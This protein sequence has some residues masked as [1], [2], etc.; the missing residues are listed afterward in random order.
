MANKELAL[1][2][3]IRKDTEE[4]SEIAFDLSLGNKE[5]TL[6]YRV[7]PEYGKY[8][9]DNCADSFV[10]SFLNFAMKFDCDI[11]SAYPISKKLMYQLTTQV[12]P[13]LAVTS[14]GFG[15]E[16]G[17]F[18]DT[19][20]EAFRNE[21]GVGTGMSCGVDSFATLYEYTELCD[22][23]EYRLTHL[24]HFNVGAHHGQTGSFK[25]ELQ[26]E[27]YLKD[28]EL[29]QRFCDEYNYK[30]IAV[31]SN[32]T[33]V[34]DDL[35]GYMDFE[36]Y[37]TYLNVAAVLLLQK[38]F[39]RYYYSAAINLDGFKISL[40]EDPAYYEKWLLPNL[41]TE[42]VTFY[43]SNK[44]WTREDKLKLISNYPPSYDWLKVCVKGETNCCKCVKCMRTIMG[45]D[46]IGKI[47]LYAGSFD[48]KIVAANRENLKTYMLCEVKK[49]EAFYTEIYE[50][51][52]K[53]GMTFSNKSKA[54]ASAYRLSLKLLPRKLYFKIKQKSLNKN[55]KVD[56][57]ELFSDAAVKRREEQRKKAGK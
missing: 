21:S 57:N 8:L 17:I 49:G 19:Y 27:L 16:I 26:R 13:Q 23:P 34:I 11:R 22:T 37:H 48:P 31:D 2:K 52:V 47:D 10:V 24:T 32:I 15:H 29:V 30:L 6:W 9:C 42:S 44:N 1:N 12:I 40:N 51:A 36:F 28:V 45:L 25:P 38:L 53:N 7:S 55:L 39:S 54:Y 18:A 14:K 4:Y 46:A 43:N 56:V 35:F 33:E 20:S 3:I 50:E 5:E 41:S